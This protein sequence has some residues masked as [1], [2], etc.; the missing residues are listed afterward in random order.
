MEANTKNTE[1]KTKRKIQIQRTVD[2]KSSEGKDSNVNRPLM[3][4]DHD[5][6]KKNCSVVVLRD[7]NLDSNAE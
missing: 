7:I 1:N 6:T 2:K 4:L 3:N 5:N